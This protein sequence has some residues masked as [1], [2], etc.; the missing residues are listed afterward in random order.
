MTSGAMPRL[1]RAANADRFWSKVAR[2]QE[3][4]CWPWTSETNNKGYGRFTIW[5]GGRRRI[6][7]HRFA[8]ENSTGTTLGPGLVL[9][10]SC[11]NPPCCNPA[12]LTPGTQVEN[13]A[14]ARARGRAV[15]PPKLRGEQINTAVLTADEVREIHVWLGLGYRLRHI[16]QAYGIGDGAIAAIRDGRTWKHITPTIDHTISRSTS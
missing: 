5:T 15:N 2:G 1:P 6:L 7:A 14:D 11:D 16:A 10:H 4:E 9:R 13:M 3:A 12:H 8:Y